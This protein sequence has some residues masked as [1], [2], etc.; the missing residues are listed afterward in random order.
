MPSLTALLSGSRSDSG[1]NE[2]PLLRAVL[3]HELTELSVLLYIH[4]QVNS[5]KARDKNI[6]P[7]QHSWPLVPLVPVTASVNYCR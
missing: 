2:D 1:G 4:K 3:V 7:G 6:A 5:T